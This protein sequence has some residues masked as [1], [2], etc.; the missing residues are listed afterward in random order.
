MKHV[1]FV[2]L[3]LLA[4]CALSSRAS[5]VTYYYYD[6]TITAKGQDAGAEAKLE[7]RTHDPVDGIMPVQVDTIGGTTT[8]KNIDIVFGGPLP[9]YNILRDKLTS[10]LPLFSPPFVDQSGLAFSI[11][12]YDKNAA[13]ILEPYPVDQTD[14]EVLNNFL[15]APDG[16]TSEKIWLREGNMGAIISIFAC[17]GNEN[18]CEFVRKI[19][20]CYFTT[21]LADPTTPLPATLPLFATGLGLFGLLR[22]RKRKKAEAAIGGLRAAGT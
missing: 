17:T 11:R 13:T 4:S 16:S 9:V 3:A 10:Q 14:Q 2:A 20:D 5:A 15:G 19:N 7:I 6:L 8:F 21:D 12:A 1:S 18:H 22:H